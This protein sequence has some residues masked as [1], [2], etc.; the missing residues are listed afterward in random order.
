MKFSS[1]WSV[2]FSSF[3]GLR[4]ILNAEMKEVHAE[5]VTDEKGEKEPVSN[6]EE[7]RMWQQGLLGEA[8]AKTLL[9]TIMGKYSEYVLKNITNCA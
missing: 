4:R 8:S 6:E 5:G 1:K 2:F 9:H 7:E 3:V